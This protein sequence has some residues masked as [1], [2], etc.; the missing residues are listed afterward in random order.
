MYSVFSTR[1]LF[2]RRSIANFLHK[3]NWFSSNA[4][5][6]LRTHTCGELRE[7][8]AGKAVV[9]CG[10][11]YNARVSSSFLLL[12]D[13]YGMT[14]ITLEPTLRNALPPTDSVVKI[15]GVVQTRPDKDI[16]ES[17]KTGK[18]E[19]KAKTVKI[20]NAASEKIP[21]KMK[22]RTAVNEQ[23]GLKYRYLQLRQVEFQKRLKFRSEFLRKLRNYLCV[24]RAFV[25]IET[26]YLF[27]RTPGGA[28]EFIVPS[29][30][31]GKF[32]SLPQ[33]PQQFKQLL[34]VAGI[35]RYVQI[36]RC[37][38][39]ELARPD[40]QPEFTQVSDNFWLDIEASFITREDIYDIIES[41]LSHAWTEVRKY[42]EKIG[43]LATPFPRMTYEEAIRNY[44]SDKPDVRFGMKLLD[45]TT[46]GDDKFA[47]FVIPAE[48]AGSLS[49]SFYQKILSLVEEKHALA[50]SQVKAGEAVVMGKGLDHAWRNALGTA[51]VLIAKQVASLGFEIYKPG[52][53]FH[54]VEN[55]PLFSR[56]DNGNFVSEHHPFTAPV[57]SDMDLLYSHPE[58]VFNVLNINKDRLVRGQHYDL[59]CNG[60]EVGGGSIRIHQH[61]MQRFILEGILHEDVSPLNHLLEALSYG[62]P[63]HGGIALGL[64]RLIAILT[65]ART[66]RD[67]IAFPKTCEGRDLLSNSP[68]TVP[69]ADL[70]RYSIQIKKTNTPAS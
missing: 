12:K 65:G 36:A 29:Q 40:R 66:V 30:L 17:M 50:I 70:D 43:Q 39:D 9:L 62:A 14:Q 19:V 10:W 69:S 55:F 20:I 2:T 44:G 13:A 61:D 56:D 1:R 23:L 59:V 67:V 42:N 34:M 6:S 27:K 25:D 24:E 7:S 21:F 32:Y 48:Y 60:Q 22:E 51:R 8:D 54:W 45:S 57:E 33:S 35:D 31:R 47:Y 41:T 64:D 28:H 37:F 38:R 11:L 52:F 16:N 3:F 4:K 18:I 46:N 63:P 68:D 49:R 26:P 15:E 5:A 58:K 53:F